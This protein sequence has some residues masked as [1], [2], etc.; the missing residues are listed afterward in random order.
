M[1]DVKKILRDRLAVEAN[2]R[3]RDPDINLDAAY[4]LASE[5]KQLQSRYETLRTDI[6]RA[7]SQNHNPPTEM[8][9]RR[10]QDLRAESQRVSTQLSEVQ[11]RLEGELLRIP[12]LLSPLV[13]I[14]QRKEDSFIVR[15]Y[16]EKPNFDFPIADHV[17]LGKNLGILDFER[18]AKI[19]GTG[20]PLYR[21][22]GAV[23]QWSLLN[24]MIEHSNRRGFEFMLFPLLNNTQT[25]T[26]SGNL[27]K[28]ADELYTCK[29]DDLHAIPTSEV[30]LTSFYRGE[31]IDGTK[32]PLRMISYSPCF[33]REAG[34]HGRASR[35]LMRLH[36]FDKVESYSI[37]KPEESEGELDFLLNNAE[38]MLKELGLHHRTARLPS[39]DLA[40]Q[41]SHTCDIELWLPSANMYSEVSS[42][43]NCTDYQARRANI[44]FKSPSQNG[45][46]HT[47]N[48]SALATP[49]LMIALMETNQKADGHITVP[50]ALRKYTGFDVI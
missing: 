27:P 10:A 33:R 12:N 24:F 49:R 35:G 1:I 21:G 30:P 38:M 17:T 5:Q 40:Q 16:G 42:A 50:P 6:K 8:E 18:S 7:S 20:F 39:C 43:S 11:G 15:S 37:C 2:L 22:K 36:Q 34:A 14:S 4:S 46:V 47:L 44:R 41:S 29:N 26:A 13:P 3:Q 25:L 9:R 19:A 28:F 31:V 23:L 45:Y 32:L 48:C